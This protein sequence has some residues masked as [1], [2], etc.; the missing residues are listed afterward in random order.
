MFLL[1]FEGFLTVG[2]AKSDM[3]SGSVALSYVSLCFTGLVQL[4][5]LWTFW[6]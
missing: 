1:I 6:R 5:G 2:Y 3:K 4:L